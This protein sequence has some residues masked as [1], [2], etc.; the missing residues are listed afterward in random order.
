MCVSNQ[1]QPIPYSLTFEN[2][3]IDW[4]FGCLIY[5]SNTTGHSDIRKEK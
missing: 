1:L 5:V 4:S 2:A 3:S